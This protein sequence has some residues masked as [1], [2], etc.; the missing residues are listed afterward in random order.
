MGKN[1]SK[2]M[3]DID[4]TPTSWALQEALKSDPPLAEF[5]DGLMVS[6]SPLSWRLLLL[7][8]GEG[9]RLPTDALKT[10]KVSWPVW[11]LEAA[12]EEN[13]REMCN[14]I[15]RFLLKK[16]DLNLAANIF[17]PS[18]AKRG[19]RVSEETKAIVST[20]IAMGNPSPYGNQLAKR[21]FGGGFKK[22]SPEKRK[23]MVD[24]CAQAVARTLIQEAA[25][26]A[27]RPYEE[28]LK[29]MNRKNR[30]RRK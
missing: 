28:S 29:T 13:S 19:R 20:W 15:L 22:A 23:Q 25:S 7:F 14:S 27:P 10:L 2:I 4:L 18:P 24:R 26:Q 11:A 12:A 8:W 21:H 30:S 5:L 3:G 9:L 17:F 1:R 16:L 6:D